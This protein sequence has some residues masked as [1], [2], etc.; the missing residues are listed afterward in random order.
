MMTGLTSASEFS[1]SE[2]VIKYTE[3]MPPWLST[4][5]SGM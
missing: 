5:I 3:I 1:S 4:E 2:F